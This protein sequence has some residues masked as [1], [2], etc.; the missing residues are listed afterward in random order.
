M[1]YLILILCL[2][3]SGTLAAQQRTTSDRPSDTE[4]A[5]GWSETHQEF[6]QVVKTYYPIEGTEDRFRIVTDSIPLGDTA[7]LKQNLL[8]T[9]Q[10]QELQI[11]RILAQ[12]IG[13]PNLERETNQM[14]QLYTA[15]D[16]SPQAWHKANT[17]QVG[18]NFVGNYLFV[19]DTSR[20]V[21]VM[22]TIPN[23]P[24]E[25]LL[26]LTKRNEDLT[27]DTSVRFVLL[28]TSDESFLISGLYQWSGVGNGTTKFVWD[29]VDDKRKRFWPKDRTMG[30]SILRV[31]T[32]LVKL[33]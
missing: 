20:F 6:I 13:V 2:L 1:R 21:M 25:G 27:L 26:R 16:A 9:A 8:E 22:D 18:S 10:D 15:I 14:R 17:E 11:S 33:Q 31:N 12:S 28:P 30:N 19:S 3:M 29:Q 5:F 4:V 23:G 7:T 24:N 32:V